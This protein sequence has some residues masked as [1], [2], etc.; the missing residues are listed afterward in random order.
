MEKEQIINECPKSQ[1]LYDYTI[2]A[3]IGD[4]KKI[5]EKHLIDCEDA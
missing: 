4:K 3:L 1:E 2:D 5:I